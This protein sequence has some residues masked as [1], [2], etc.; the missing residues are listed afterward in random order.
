MLQARLKHPAD[1]LNPAV[2]Q[3]SPLVAQVRAEL[4]SQM[5]QWG[6][7]GCFDLPGRWELGVPWVL[8]L[9]GLQPCRGLLD[10]VVF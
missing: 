4:G 10:S 6:G 8:P 5:E 2:P 3:I 7:A 1:G 9:G